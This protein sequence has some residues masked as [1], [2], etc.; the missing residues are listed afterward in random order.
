M[1]SEIRPKA[2]RHYISLPILGSVLDEFTSW[3]RQRGYSIVTVRCQ[4]EAARKID[5]FFRQHG[6]QSLTDLTHS[7]FEA[8]WH[9]YRHRG[10]NIS[11]TVRHIEQFLEETRGLVS[12]LSQPKTPIGSELDRFADHLRNVR[13]LET[14][15]I[16]CHTRYLQNFLEYIRYDV[17]T[18]VLATLTS[19]EIEGFICICAKRLN[20]YT[21]Q[22]V[23]GYLQAF[24]RFQYEQGA[25][26]SPLHTMIDTPRIYRLE[27]L[28]RS[29]PWETVKA[30]SP[31]DL[32]CRRARGL[33]DPTSQELAAHGDDGTACLERIRW[34]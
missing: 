22:H 25:L 29:L 31:F 32:R 5:G 12:P 2:Y 9:Y 34:S 27:Q 8:A 7:S 18:Q 20:R 15:T 4:L 30:H 24:L 28:P 21:L 19:K 14:A 26:Q 16:Q 1:I 6:A 23:V 13:G 33:P 10:A 17:N 11:G 3:S